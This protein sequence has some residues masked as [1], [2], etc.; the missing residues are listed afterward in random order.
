[1]KDNVTI[2]LGFGMGVVAFV[3]LFLFWPLGILLGIGAI[4]AVFSGSIKSMSGK[5]KKFFC[6]KCQFKFEKEIK[7]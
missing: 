7:K 3:F 2:I 4:I 1:M 6:Q 5:S